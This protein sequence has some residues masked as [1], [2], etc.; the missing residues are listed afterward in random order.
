MTGVRA[1]WQGR[2]RSMT[3]VCAQ[4]GRGDSRRQY[5]RQDAGSQVP[6]PPGHGWPGRPR[7]QYRAIFSRY[8]LQTPQ[9]RRERRDKDMQ[10]SVDWQVEAASIPDPGE[11]RRAR[12]P[13]RAGPRAALACACGRW[14]LA[15]PVIRPPGYPRIASRSALPLRH[16]DHLS[17]RWL[18]FLTRPMAGFF[19]SRAH[20]R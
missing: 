4:R 13:G 1:A 17:P 2:A 11:H 19:S 8:T 15:H 20:C 16:T 7:F 3:G 14:R 12:D 6:L 10:H 9:V 5:Q 18:S